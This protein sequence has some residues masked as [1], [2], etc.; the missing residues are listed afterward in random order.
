MTLSRHIAFSQ[1]DEEEW[2][3][4]VEEEEEEGEAIFLFFTIQSGVS[5]S[6]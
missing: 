3:E 6:D 2:E 4:G 5:S 1:T